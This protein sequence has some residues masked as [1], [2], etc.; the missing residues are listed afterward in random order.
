MAVHGIPRPELS[1]LVIHADDPLWCGVEEQDL[2]GV[3][4]LGGRQEQVLAADAD[5]VLVFVGTACHPPVLFLGVEMVPQPPRF[6]TIAGGSHFE[7]PPSVD[8]N[9]RQNADLVPFATYGHVIIGVSLAPE[10]DIGE[11]AE[12]LDTYAL[13]T[14]ALHFGGEGEHD[15]GIPDDFINAVQEQNQCVEKQYVV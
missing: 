15:D 9:K 11:L 7:Y 1:V 6:D 8:R 14:K 5:L 13:F 4:L 3:L 10:Y 2:P 12:T